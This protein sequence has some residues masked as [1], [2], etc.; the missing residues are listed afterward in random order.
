MSL[1]LLYSEA[2]YHLRVSYL[3]QFPKFCISLWN[4]SAVSLWWAEWGEGTIHYH[5][6]TSENQMNLRLILIGPTYLLLTE[7]VCIPKKKVKISVQTN[8]AIQMN[9]KN[10]NCLDHWGLLLRLLFLQS[11]CKLWHLGLF[12]TKRMIKTNWVLRTNACVPLTWFH[13][14]D[15]LLIQLI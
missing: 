11:M 12:F 1:W 10:Q 5:L 4:W 8:K 2:H 9:W 15:L 14:R 6:V 3:Q 7:L 13:C